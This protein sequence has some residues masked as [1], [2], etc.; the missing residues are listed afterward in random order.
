MDPELRSLL[1][2]MQLSQ[3][4]LGTKLDA[5][6]AEIAAMLNDFAQSKVRREDEKN[7]DQNRRAHR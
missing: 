4:M 1:E 7:A 5:Q 2:G 3:T 6:G